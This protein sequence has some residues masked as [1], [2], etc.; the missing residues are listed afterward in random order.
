M[1]EVRDNFP[2]VMVRILYDRPGNA[3]LGLGQQSR[4]PLAVN[5]DAISY[6]H[7]VLQREAEAV[8]DDLHAPVDL[9]L[10]LKGAW[11][12]VCRDCD[13][14]VLS[15]RVDH[16]GHNLQRSVCQNDGDRDSISLLTCFPS[17]GGSFAR[18]DWVAVPRVWSWT[19]REDHSEY[20]VARECCSS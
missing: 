5:V 17:S 19:V 15:H 12:G 18:T 13:P 9:L 10:R 14:E 7:V 4:E 20:M 8:T 3:D 16:R 1:V 2:R 11:L 6:D